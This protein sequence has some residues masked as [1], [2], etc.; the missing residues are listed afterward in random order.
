[1]ICP[2]KYVV[3]CA[4]KIQLFVVALNTAAALLYSC[5][6]TIAVGVM[7]VGPAPVPTLMIMLPVLVVA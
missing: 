7:I 2:E 5:V 4:V 6:A 3:D 1:V